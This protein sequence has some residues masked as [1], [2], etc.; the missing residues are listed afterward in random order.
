M[1]ELLSQRA[2]DNF[3]TYRIGMIGV[4]PMAALH[5]AAIRNVPDLRLAACAARSLGRAQA[6]AATWNVPRATTVDE[7][8]ASPDVD[9]LWVVA[10]ADA[11]AEVATKAS[12]AGLP[13]FLEKPVGLDLAETEAAASTVGVP[14]LVGLNRRFY[15]VLQRGAEIVAEAGGLR[16]IEVHMPEDLRPLEGRYRGKALSNWQYGNSIHLIDLFRY[17]G[18]EVKRVTAQPEVG[19]YWDRSYVAMIEFENGAR[20]IYNAQWYAPGPWR[21]SLYANNVM[22]QYA[23]LEKGLV[24]RSPGRQQ[25]TIEPSGPDKDLKPGLGGQAQA[26]AHLLRTGTLPEGASDLKGYARSV[27]LVRAL[28]EVA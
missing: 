7:L 12:R 3:M 8:V 28:T 23:P 15:E 5:A 9:A 16:F 19:D 13:L 22:I 25:S 17:F 27:A 4:G 6:F 10:P 1:G 21:V 2:S 14:N 26:F 11:M 20:G 18:G 24:I